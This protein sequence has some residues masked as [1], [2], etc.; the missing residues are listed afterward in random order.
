MQGN[1]SLDS[2]LDVS[3]EKPVAEELREAAA[4][5][6]SAEPS[7]EQ[8]GD[9][10]SAVPPADANPE[11]K[12]EPETWTKQAV[13]DERRK[14]QELEKRLNELQ[15]RLT[16]AQQGAQQ[17]EQ[18][19]PS[20]WD[21]PEDAARAL[22]AQVQM[23]VFESRVAL[24]ERMMREKHQDYDEVATL[25]AKRC[26]SDPQITH[27]LM[28]HPF[29]AEYAYQL[30][31]KIRLMDEIGQDPSAYREKLR[32][33]LRAELLAEMGHQ[34]PASRSATAQAQKPTSGAVPR[35]LAR[36]V[37]AQP[38]SQSGQFAPY[39]SRASLDDILG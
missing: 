4:E 8:T 5:P 7:A 39:D 33:D 36:D 18:P 1:D 23:Q 37:S 32:E 31:Q 28:Q 35:S 25:F 11:A 17:Q 34:T 9:K 38:R 30:G 27:Q 3:A 22:Q 16:P 2:L 14:R 15:E 19:A 24:S 6:Q 29:P 10:Q 12:I 20:W 26:H 21:S 13:L